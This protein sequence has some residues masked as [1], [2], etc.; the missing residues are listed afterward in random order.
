MCIFHAETPAFSRL[1]AVEGVIRSCSRAGVM[2]KTRGKFQVGRV[3]MIS[4]LQ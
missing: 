2:A 1:L 3:W 4:L